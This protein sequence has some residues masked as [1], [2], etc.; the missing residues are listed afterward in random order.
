MIRWLA[1][2]IIGIFIGCSSAPPVKKTPEIQ[3]KVTE[4]KIPPW[5]TITQLESALRDDKKPD[6]ILL[7]TMNC[8][9]CRHLHEIMD[10]MN[11]TDKVLFINM[12]EPWVR[13]LTQG[14]N[15]EVIP[16]LVI[17]LDGGGPKTL[18]FSGLEGI[19]TALFDQFSV[20]KQRKR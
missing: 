17:T 20:K 15:I 16:T 1:I 14:V 2:V 4:H 9:T 6:Y 19:T 5:I 12:E 11:W 3:I 8:V 18:G 7:S 10:Q 13:K